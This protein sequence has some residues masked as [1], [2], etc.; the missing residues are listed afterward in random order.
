MNHV[1]SSKAGIVQDSWCRSTALGAKLR[2]HY[3]YHRVR[4]KYPS[5]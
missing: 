3:Q 4:C 1:N 5:M 2:G